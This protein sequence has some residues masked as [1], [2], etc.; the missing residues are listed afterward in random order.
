MVRYDFIGGADFCSQ[1]ACA[2]G[3]NFED[4]KKVSPGFETVF[5]ISYVL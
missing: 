1:V 4:A 2:V 3:L 5:D